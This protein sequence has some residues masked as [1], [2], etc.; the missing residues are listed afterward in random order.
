MNKK[1]L[2]LT[3][4]AIMSITLLA[5]CGAKTSGTSDNSLNDIKKKGEFVVGL[6][7]SFPPMG[8]KDDKGN[9][10][11]FDIDL[12]NEAAKRMGVK[13]V[14]KPVAWDGILMSLNNKD[15]DL[16]WNGLTITDDRKKQI[17]FSK[18]YLENKQIIVVKSDSNIS[19]KKD[20]SGKIVALQLGSSSETALNADSVTAKS[21][22]EI[23]KF[24]DN[25]QAL[26]DLQSG[27][28]DAVVV[29]EVVGRY[30]MSKKPG[31]YKVLDEDFGKESYGVG[32]RKSDQ[33]FKAE[34]DKTLDAMKADGTADKISEK[35]FGKAII[36]K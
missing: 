27:R 4:T 7:D 12:A 14:F 32:I 8:F 13:A 36:A 9:I 28:V 11:G 17:D 23:R 6:D 16:I 18:V 21:I 31:V 34:L 25:T 24:D 1:I 15:I 10:V 33:T 22:K 26:M 5:G 19:A 29:D 35:W 2:A 30:Y 20:L 3:I